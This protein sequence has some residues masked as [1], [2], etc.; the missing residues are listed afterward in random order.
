RAA[1]FDAACAA[2]FAGCCRGADA[3]KLDDKERAEL[4]TQARTW[5]RGLLDA[6]A[7]RVKDRQEAH[8]EQTQR[9]LAN[10][11]KEAAF[12]G[13]RD[14]DA[15]AR[16]PDAERAAWEKLWQDVE[17]LRQRAGTPKSPP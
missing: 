2:A 3:D 14:P 10:W 7:R 16:L 5:L 15:R 1:P 13:G 8:G 9:N 4:R 11:Q 6:H 12:T 17:A